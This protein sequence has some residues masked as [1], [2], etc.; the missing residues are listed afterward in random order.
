ML[1]SWMCIRRAVCAAAIALFVNLGCSPEAGPT[2]PTGPGNGA[3]TGIT[4]IELRIDMATGNVSVTPPPAP[5]RADGSPTFSLLGSD[6]IRM[7]TR[8]G[9]CAPSPSGKRFVRCTFEL[10][11]QNRLEQRPST[12]LVTPATLPKPPAGV[13]GIL[14]FPFAAEGVP[15]GTATPSTDWDHAP[16][17]MFNDVGGCGRTGSDCYR[18]ELY[19]GGLGGEELSEFRQVGFDVEKS[20]TSV[21]VQIA[22]AADFGEVQGVAIGDMTSCFEVSRRLAT[23]DLP[24]EWY[25]LDAGEVNFF[26][27]SRPNGDYRGICQFD[28]ASFTEEKRIVEAHL[29]FLQMDLRGNPLEDFEGTGRQMLLADPVW[30]NPEALPEPYDLYH[31]EGDVSWDQGSHEIAVPSGDNFLQRGPVEAA[32]LRGDAAARYRIRWA[33]DPTRQAESNGVLVPTAPVIFPRLIV[34]WVDR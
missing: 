15:S 30:W 21:V 27:G 2:A 25:S 14:V 20:A 17:N 8:N 11:V 19:P 23:E 5:L 3:G 22:V 16:I 26:V 32:L 13:R 31:A 28:L 4:A 29:S 6:V 18:Y 34:H 10:A 9:A 7:E 33:H 12:F 24:Q 1:H